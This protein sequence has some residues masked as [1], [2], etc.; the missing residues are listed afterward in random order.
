MAFM[1][2]EPLVAK[3]A[4]I[5]KYGVLPGAMIAALIYSPPDYVSS[6]KHDHASSSK[7]LL[8]ATRYMISLELCWDLMD[9]SALCDV[10]HQFGFEFDEC[11][12]R[13]IPS[14]TV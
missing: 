6:K 7:L 12:F 4:V 13:L 14:W 5:A 10:Y 8:T 11:K 3:L 1:R 2:G 9:G